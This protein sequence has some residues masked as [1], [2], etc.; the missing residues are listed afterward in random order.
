MHKQR[1][2]YEEESL[3]K[4][5]LNEV[6]ERDLRV[7][8]I[9][10]IT[11][12]RIV[13]RR[14]ELG[15]FK[16]WSDLQGIPYLGQKKMEILTENFYIGTRNPG[17]SCY[18]DYPNKLRPSSAA[19]S[20]SL[21][22]LLG[23]GEIIKE[24]QVSREAQQP[25]PKSRFLNK[26]PAQS[27]RQNFET[28]KQTTKQTKTQSNLDK[29]NLNNASERE[30]LSIP[31]IEYYITASKIVDRRKELGHFTQWSDLENISYLNKQNIKALK[32]HCVITGK[33]STQTQVTNN[34]KKTKETPQSQ[35]KPTYMPH[36]SQDL[37]KSVTRHPKQSFKASLYP[38]HE[39]IKQDP[40]GY[41]PEPY[42]Y[43]EVSSSSRKIYS[44]IKTEDAIS[45]HTMQRDYALF[46]V[47]QEPESSK[48]LQTLH[49]THGV[50][51][52][53]IEMT[54]ATE[55]GYEHLLKYE[56]FPESEALVPIGHTSPFKSKKQFRSVKVDRGLFLLHINIQSLI[57]NKHKL[58]KF[59]GFDDEDV[60]NP[61]IICFTEARK[62]NPKSV[63]L[64]DYDFFNFHSRPNT[65]PGG[66]AMYVKKTL[67]YKARPD[68]QFKIAKC[69]TLWVEVTG[70]TE[71]NIIV[72][73]VY[74]HDAL[75]ENF[76]E[77]EK[78]LQRNINKITKK[79][80][81]YYILGDIN[82]DMLKS[83]K[84][85]NRAVEHCQ[86][87][88]ELGCNLLIT[89]P[90]RDPKKTR[91]NHKVSLLDHIYTNDNAENLPAGVV[92]VAAP[93]LTDHFPVYCIVPP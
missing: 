43:N 47:K 6:D 44:P 25:T 24:N 37:A 51:P 31:G 53:E 9:G 78:M 16:D 5:D 57:T 1:Y 84:P 73:C 92:L 74:R 69:E 4:M 59:V 72:G 85:N 42:R 79:K 20:P 66:V 29:L 81:L 91:A 54:A 58:H 13:D 83:E 30:I 67:N 11:A 35:T 56:L 55:E 33:T 70:I 39:Q 19:A 49:H 75:R 82:L 10:E 21:A 28:V 36:N 90:T 40:Y 76:D 80:Q 3:G 8:G 68:L 38:A 50:N 93:E 46:K 17:T 34:T 18:N 7:P 52:H 88:K 60:Q 77:F 45:K 64:D 61:D 65:I 63:E 89:R 86:L 48:P 12:E 87:L 62:P 22:E 32:Q 23:L 27:E 26:A 14:E 2:Y 15:Y 41:T 71:V